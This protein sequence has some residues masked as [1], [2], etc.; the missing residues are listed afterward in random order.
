MSI[1][2]ISKL[3]IPFLVRGI[4]VTFYISLMSGILALI[5]GIFGGFIRTT[6][7]FI[8]RWLIGLYVTFFRGTPFL[9]QLYIVYY[10]FPD[11]VGIK[12]NILPTGVGVL[13]LNSGA[14][15]TEIFRAGI[16][17]IPKEQSE[18][19]FSLGMKPFQ[20][21][22]LIIFPQVMRIVIP[23]LVGQL[24]LLIKDTS[25]ISLIGIFDVVRVGKELANNSAWGNPLL[26]YGWVAFFYFIICYPL[27]LYSIKI[28][29]KLR[30]NNS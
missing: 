8:V 10:V 9:I 19:A 23:P 25:V 24:I 30:L 28:E 7:I 15:I 26:I 21:S 12:L 1:I 17:A 16:E 4:F 6:N 5:I 20:K 29:K 22:R 11:F 2:E 3:A 18:A 13:A 27:Y 14:Y